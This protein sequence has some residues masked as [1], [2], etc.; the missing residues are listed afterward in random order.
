MRRFDRDNLRRSHIN[1]GFANILS[2][3]ADLEQ[4]KRTGN[5]SNS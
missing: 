3:G 2:E 5:L 4:H 1:L